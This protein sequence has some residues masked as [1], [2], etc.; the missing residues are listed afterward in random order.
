M[1][2]IVVV[3]LPLLEVPLGRLIEDGRA[4]RIELE[5]IVHSEEGVIPFF[6]VRGGVD[7][8]ADANGDSELE[9]AIRDTDA[10]R[11]LAE[12][13]R[14]EDGRLYRAEWSEAIEGFVRTVG[15]IGATIVL[16]EGTEDGWR[17]ELRFADRGR[18]REFREYCRDSG[19]PIEID[20]IATVRE[21][22]ART[23]AGYGLTDD[24]RETLRRAYAEGYFDEPRGVTQSELADAF[25]VSQRAV[26]DRLRGAL[27]R[28]V[29][30]TVAT[31]IDRS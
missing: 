29:E 14:A 12:V 27:S 17:F 31:D 26:S 21:G 25:G 23:D 1:A 13:T 19:V 11:L 7:G 24:Q 6:W 9:A 4:R 5:R 2:T 22:D 18:I 3:R 20:R 16:G 10:V 30:N 28:L 8:D 15:S